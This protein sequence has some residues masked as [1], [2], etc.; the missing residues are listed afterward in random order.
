MKKGFFFSNYKYMRYT[1]CVLTTDYGLRTSDYGL[2]KNQA[3]LS[4]ATLCPPQ[5]N[6][7]AKASKKKFF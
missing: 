1:L 3:H 6:L 7:R 5:P 4:P 2:N